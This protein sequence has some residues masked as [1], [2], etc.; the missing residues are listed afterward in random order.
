MIYTLENENQIVRILAEK[1]NGT[2]QA[3]TIFQLRTQKY[4]AFP[5]LGPTYFFFKANLKNRLCN[6]FPNNNDSVRSINL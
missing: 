2:K 1:P 5:A 4:E 3:T 6:S